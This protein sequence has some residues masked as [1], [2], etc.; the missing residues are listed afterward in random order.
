MWWGVSAID[1][2]K[3]AEARAVTRDA[4]QV[5][6]LLQKVTFRK[7]LIHTQRHTGKCTIHVHVPSELQSIVMHTQSNGKRMC[8]CFQ[9]KAEGQ[10][11]AGILGGEGKRMI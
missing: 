5:I 11:R 6:P 4:H 10:S 9:P 1:D 2:F 8:V 7:F 3:A